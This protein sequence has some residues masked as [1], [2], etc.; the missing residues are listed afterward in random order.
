ML[1]IIIPA[2]NEEKYL[3]LL[4]D[5]IK[6]QDF[7]DYE[8]IIADADSTDKTV[9]IAKKYGCRIVRG[10]LPAK[11]RNEG[12]KEAKADL[13]LFLDA[14]VILPKGFLAE[15]LQKFKKN[16]LDIATTALK[17]IGSKKAYKIGSKLWNFY[18][19][20]NQIFLPCAG[21]FCLLV[22]KELH[23]KLGGFDEKIKVGEDFIYAR[24]SKK[25][26]K[27]KFFRSPKFLISTRRAEKEG[28]LKSALKYILI[29]LHMVF[30]GPVK[31]DIFRYKFGHCLKEK[32]SL[33]LFDRFLQKFKIKT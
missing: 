5:S 13:L 18:F 24:K 19:W 15:F 32:D 8:I 28:L 11:G 31:S 7:K 4:L 12:V 30:L 25:F 33:R 22:K 6:K 26:A 17:M 9:E 21:G 14:D 23:R 16:K 2:L 3:P 10:G 27:F 29:D 20:T 1:S